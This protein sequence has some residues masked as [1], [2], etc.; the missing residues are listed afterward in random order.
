MTEL[1]KKEFLNRL[2]EKIKKLSS[3]A[4]T[5]TF[6]FQQKW[7]DFLDKTDIKPHLVRNIPIEEEK[8]LND[9]D[10]RISTLKLVSQAITDGF[11][12]IKS[13]IEALYKSYFN[14]NMFKQQYSEEDQLKV[15]YIVAK[16]ILGNLIQYNKLD[17]ETIPLKYNVIARNYTLLKLKVQSDKSIIDNMNKIFNNELNL[18]QIQSVLKEVEADGIIS[19]EQQNDENFY[20]LKNELKLSEEG[21][22]SYTQSIYQLIIWPT[23][24]WRSFYNIRELNITPGQDIEDRDFLQTVLSRSAT[25]GFGPT[26]YVFKNLIKYY[27]K[28]KEELS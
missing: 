1:S 13:L 17:H 24:F 4:K 27:E 25:Q 20:K 26:D 15:K 22:K 21:E 9:I 12:T 16:E 28:I 10:Y 23:N 3:I 8:F 7:N 6:R 19:I 5:Q 11:Y 14:S 2:L 18:G